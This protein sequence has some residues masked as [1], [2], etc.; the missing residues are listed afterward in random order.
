MKF[1]ESTE[2]AVHEESDGE[3][4]NQNVFDIWSWFYCPIES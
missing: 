1:L 2:K 3:K 4:R